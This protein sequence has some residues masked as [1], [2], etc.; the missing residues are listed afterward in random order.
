MKREFNY[1]CLTSTF[2]SVSYEVSANSVMTTTTQITTCQ[3]S[4][5]HTHHHPPP[6]DHNT[7]TIVAH[8]T[9]TTANHNRPTTVAHTRPPH[10]HHLSSQHAHHTPTTAAHNG[11]QVVP[12]MTIS[13]AN[14]CTA[15][16]DSI[17]TV[18]PCRNN[19]IE[20][21]ILY[22]FCYSSWIW[23]LHALMGIL[24]LYSVVL[25]Y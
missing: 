12:Q 15:G 6:A 22:N 19:Y 9:P 1:S 18:P 16:V 20:L 17:N 7:P 21:C 11:S 25:L 10:T 23:L 3:G 4:L 2:Q 24:L 13:A 14:P 5:Q 8:N